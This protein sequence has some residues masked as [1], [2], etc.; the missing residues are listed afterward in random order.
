MTNTS[1]NLSLKIVTPPYYQNVYLALNYKEN[2]LTME[3]CDRSIL[4]PIGASGFLT[5]ASLKAANPTVQFN[6]TYNFTF[7]LTNALGIGSYIRITF[8]NT[9]YIPNGPCTARVSGNSSKIAFPSFT[10]CSVAVPLYSTI[11]TVSISN[12]SLGPIAAST[13]IVI[14]VDNFMNPRYCIVTSSFLL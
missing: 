13:V 14:E 5:Q 11:G 9:V 2:N 10:I 8:P 12:F 1:I 7:L 4:G 6:T 3:S